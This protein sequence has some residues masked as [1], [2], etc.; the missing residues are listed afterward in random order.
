MRKRWLA[1]TALLLLPAAAAAELFDYGIRSQ[2]GWGDNVYGVPDELG[3][4]DDYSI[5]FSPWGRVSDP[6]GKLTWSLRYQ[7]SYEYFVNE[8]DLRNFD[9]DVGADLAWQ[10]GE[11]TTLLFSEIYQD[12]DSAQRFN[13][14]AGVPS[15]PAVLRTQQTK[16]INNFTTLG[17]RHNLTPRDQFALN[18]GY[19]TREYPEA[20]GAGDL[21]SFRLATSLNRALDTRTR[22]G[23]SGSWI[24]Q[25]FQRRVGEDSVTDYYNLSGTLEHQL[26]RTLR[27]ELEAGPTLIDSNDDLASFSQKY[28]VVRNPVTGALVA[29]DANQCPLL[30]DTLP[31]QPDPD[32]PNYNPHV[33]STGFGRCTVSSNFLTRGE[34]EALGWRRGDDPLDPDPANP[35]PAKLTSFDQVYEL[36]ANGTLDPVDDSDS[37][38]LDLTYFAR[39]AIVKDWERWQAELSYERSADQTGSLGVSSV[40]DAFEVTLRWEPVRLWSFVL[41]GAYVLTDQASNVAVPRSLIVE[42]EAAPAG[43]D[44]VSQIATVQRMVVE[45]DDDAASYA[46]ASV[47]LTA[48]RQLE[49]NSWVFATL[50]WYRQ[51]QELDLDE[52]FSFVPGSASVTDDV[53][54]WT[55]LTLRVGIEYH[56]DTLKF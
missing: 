40:Q 52:A 30:N 23:L 56:F 19:F 20:R 37:D 45:V 18:G 3:T 34:L 27:F 32:A 43:V 4:I 9:H 6:D 8:A 49:L 5:R 29:L 26:S 44:S 21:S 36:N 28:G 50:Y 7:P 31:H 11:R 47:S 53:V 10:V 22:V 48:R 42:N 33:A 16:V 13:E 38:D 17:L 46:S 39:A 24:Q 51:E 41:K 35:K 12:Y 25:T 15:A 54:D 14:N 2:V 55:S 1:T